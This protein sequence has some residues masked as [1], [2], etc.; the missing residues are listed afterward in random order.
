MYTPPPYEVGVEMGDPS[1]RWMK[2]R[3][4]NTHGKG[5]VGVDIAA[6]DG[7]G[8]AEDDHGSSLTRRA[9]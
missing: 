1:G 3:K 2:V 6:C 8:G 9:G 7:H 4:A 5:A